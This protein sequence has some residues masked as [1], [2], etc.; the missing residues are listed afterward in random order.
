MFHVKKYFLFLAGIF[1]TFILMGCGRNFPANDLSV[2]TN[3][4]LSD[5]TDG[6]LIQAE[7][8]SLEDQMSDSVLSAV[9]DTTA[10]GESSECTAVEYSYQDFYLSVDVPDGWN[11]E[12]KT[13]EDRAKEDGLVVCSICFWPE[14]YA[15]AV[16]ELSYSSIRL[17]MCATGVT[18]EHFTLS[19]S[20]SGTSYTETIEDIVWM[21]FI[22]NNPYENLEDRPD[23]TYY[24]QASI[25]ASVWDEIKEEFEQILDSVWV[26]TDIVLCE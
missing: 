21:T 22:L 16:F 26:G 1:C 17:G 13:A 12:I 9:E 8:G 6:T 23:G 11:Y 15:D 7:Q 10:Y 19:N 14:K 25:D 5:L 18:I 2:N 3:S 20:I 24:I 4:S